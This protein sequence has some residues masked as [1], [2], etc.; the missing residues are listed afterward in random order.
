MPDAGRSPPDRVHGP[1]FLLDNVR[2]TYNVGAIFRVA[3]AAGVS[4]LHLCG[5]TPT[6]EN[7]KV[8]KTALGAESA[9][10]WSHHRNAVH[11][12]QALRTEGNLICVLE[13]EATARS[14]L[15]HQLLPEKPIVLVLGSE[16]AG[17]D[18]ALV[19]LADLVVAV[20]MRGVKR[21][22][23]VATVAGIAAYAVRSWT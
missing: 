1:A 21:S 23:N 17:V 4:H 13:S 18:P 16:V 6:P 7:H 8:A 3:D 20:P 14:L 15:E 9:V 5:I 12:A 10:S 19:S 11:A 2:S 22:L